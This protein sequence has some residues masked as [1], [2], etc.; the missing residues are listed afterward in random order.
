MQDHSQLYEISLFRQPFS[1]VGS[2]SSDGERAYAGQLVFAGPDAA[3]E[4]AGNRIAGYVCGKPS[5]PQGQLA[6]LI[7]RYREAI[8]RG[9]DDLR[10]RG[11]ETVVLAGRW[12]HVEPELEPRFEAYLVYLIARDGSVTTKRYESEIFGWDYPGD[13]GGFGIYLNGDPSGD[14]DACAASTRHRLRRGGGEAFRSMTGLPSVDAILWYPEKDEN[15]PMIFSSDGRNDSFDSV[16]EDYSANAAAIATTDG[17]LA[18]ALDAVSRRLISVPGDLRGLAVDRSRNRP[19]QL[20]LHEVFSSTDAPG[21][22]FQT[23]DGQSEPYSS[24]IL[25]IEPP[26]WG[27]VILKKV[28][29]PDAHGLGCMYAS[30]WWGDGSMDSGEVG[31]Q[32][33]FRLLAVGGAPRLPHQPL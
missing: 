9:A 21:Y 1:P 7:G 26:E 18:S 20:T 14:F 29:A 19:E 22:W 12:H 4:I 8:L 11:T 5:H 2:A 10:E 24:L 6:A 3:I 25:P 30:D 33:T 17:T 15:L 27:D 32:Y 28:D 13:G 16:G 23:R 31:G